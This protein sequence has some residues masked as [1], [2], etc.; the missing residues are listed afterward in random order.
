MKS[1][2]VVLHGEKK[3]KVNQILCEKMIGG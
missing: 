1:K 3:E 2:N